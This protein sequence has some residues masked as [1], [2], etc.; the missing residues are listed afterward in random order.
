MAAE[1]SLRVPDALASDTLACRAPETCCLHAWCS[2]PQ[3]NTNQP[4]AAR[5]S[6]E[7][8]PGTGGWPGLAVRHSGYPAILFLVSTTYLISSH[9]PA[10]PAAARGILPQLWTTWNQQRSRRSY[11]PHRARAAG[12]T[13]RTRTPSYQSARRR[14][15][16]LEASEAGTTTSQADLTSRPTP[17]R[18]VYARHMLDYLSFLSPQILP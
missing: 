18:Y 2:P 13:E 11:L 5:G 17:T 7:R 8:K 12:R 16:S 1:A 6:R 4:P 3:H 14:R 10:H 9:S 15:P